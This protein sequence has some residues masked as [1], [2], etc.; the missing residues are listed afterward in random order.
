MNYW[1]KIYQGRP[2]YYSIPNEPSYA[3][4]VKNISPND[5]V[6]DLGCGQGALS[7]LLNNK[8]TGLDYSETAIKSARDKYPD[9]TWII[10]DVRDLESF[11]DNSYDVVVM[12]HFLENCEDWKK[13]IQDAFRIANKKVIINLRKEFIEHDSNRIDFEDDTFEWRINYLELNDV[14]RHLS[15]NVSFGKVNDEEFV[16]IGKHLDEVVFELDDECDE[17]SALPELLKLKERFPKLKVTLF[18][19]PSKCSSEHIQ[20]L[21]QYDWIELGVHGWFHDTKEH[22]RAQESN[23]WTEE[24]ANKY[25]DMAEEMNCFKKTFRP[26]GWGLNQETY[27]VLIERGYIICDHLGH[28]RWEELGGKRYTTGHLMEVHGHTWPCNMNGIEELSTTKCNFGDNTNFY[29]ITEAP[30]DRYLPN[31]YQ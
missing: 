30:L 18:C 3:E 31:R 13:V 25:L 20:K 6:L 28:D 19:I 7:S 4:I 8:Y 11:E 27:K 1:E 23:H 12:R 26:P 10:G 29:F 16:I 9:K 24:E 15:T 17:T 21:Q 22:G 14:A 2:E 5:S